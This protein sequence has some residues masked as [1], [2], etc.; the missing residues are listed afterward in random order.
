MDFRLPNVL[1]ALTPL[2]LPT[3]Y[4][5]GLLDN[6]IPVAQGWLRMF[7]RHGDEKD[8]PEVPPVGSQLLAYVVVAIFGFLLTDRLVPNIQVRQACYEQWK[9]RHES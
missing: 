5:L 4:L 9:S 1:L 7:L 3:W 6:P 2:A 8:S